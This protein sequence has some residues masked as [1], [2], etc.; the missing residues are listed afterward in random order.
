MMKECALVAKKVISEA[1][2]KG[3][4]QLVELLVQHLEVN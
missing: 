2:A 3:N 4:E 1:E